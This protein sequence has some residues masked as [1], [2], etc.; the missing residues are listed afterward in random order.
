LILLVAMLVLAPAEPPGS[1]DTLTVSECARRAADAA[2]AVRVARLA[3][4]AAVFDSSA[5]AKNRRPGLDLESGVTIAPRGF[6][7]PTITNLG[8]YRLLLGASGALADGGTRARARIEAGL[9]ARGAAADEAQSAREAATRAIEVA[10]GL[11]QSDARVRQLEETLAWTSDLADIV[12]AGVR[13]GQR[14]RA[15]LV[16]VE[17]QRDAT[18]ADLVAARG[19]RG[20]LVR[21]LAELLG[22][23]PGVA[24]A[25][26]DPGEAAETAPTVDDSLALMA[27]AE[28][29]P[30]SRTAAVDSARAEVALDEVRRRSALQL[31]WIANAGLWGADLTRAVPLDVAAEHPGAT[32]GDRLRRDLG[33]SVGIDLRK[34]LVDPARSAALSARGAARSGASLHAR[35]ITAQ[36]RREALDLLETWRAAAATVALARGALDAAEENAVRLKN[37]YVGGGANLLDVFE[38]RSQLDDAR[39]RLLNARFE[40]R[41]A[42]FVAE[43]P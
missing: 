29:S 10:L 34:P 3:R 15:D 18:Q 40:V 27:R 8:E 12:D 31:T 7:D 38:S 24:P 30:E 37:L 16:R 42:H 28:R 14:G 39:L 36:K 41:R 19:A 6:Y 13:S 32:F 9:T 21:E 22:S 17:L 11:L 2:P 5:T 25:L 4:A 35:A 23:T 26:L 20:A 1:A 43:T 33:A